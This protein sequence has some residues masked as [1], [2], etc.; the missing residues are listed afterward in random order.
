MTFRRSKRGENLQDSFLIQR[1]HWK[2]TSENYAEKYLR[3][4]DRQ[5]GVS[6]VYDAEENQYYYNAYCVEAKI[7]KE[8]FSVEYSFLDEALETINDEFGTW[9]L[10]SFD[11]KGGGCGNCAAK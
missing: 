4:Q 2:L 7:V 5:A 1:K 10:A 11:E 6:L 9:E 3:F 8:L